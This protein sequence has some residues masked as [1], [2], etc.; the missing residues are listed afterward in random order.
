MSNW[1][2][3]HVWL[4]IQPLHV[5]TP[6]G[7]PCFREDSHCVVLSV[8]PLHFLACVS[9]VKGRAVP[10]MASAPKFSEPPPGLLHPRTQAGFSMAARS[11]EK[12]PL[13]SLQRP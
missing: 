10:P 9:G 12:P 6:A 2:G 13:L 7:S 4:Q 11:H 5:L 1:R 8:R 3:L